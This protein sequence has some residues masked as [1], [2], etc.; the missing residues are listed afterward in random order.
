MENNAPSRS[1]V[2]TWGI[3]G[4]AFAESGILGLIFSIIG[5]NKAKAYIAAYGQLDGPAKVGGILSKV[6]LILSIVMIVCYVIIII[7]SV[8]SGLGA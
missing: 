6:G 2:L 3:L 4:L 7:A 5:R 8:A 1:N